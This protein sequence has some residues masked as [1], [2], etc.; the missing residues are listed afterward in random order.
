MSM[1]VG[2]FS[3]LPALNIKICVIIWP[4]KANEKHHVVKSAL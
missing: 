2:L 1:T 4:F 3:A